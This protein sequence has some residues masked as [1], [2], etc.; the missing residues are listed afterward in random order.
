MKYSAA[1][2]SAPCSRENGKQGKANGLISI[3]V[4]GIARIRSKMVCLPRVSLV[5]AAQRKS[6]TA[7]CTALATPARLYDKEKK[8]LQLFDTFAF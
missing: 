2:M 3:V 4:N 5:H 7:R 8:T 1:V 6:T